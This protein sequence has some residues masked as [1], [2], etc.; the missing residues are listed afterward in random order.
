MNSYYSIFVHVNVFL[1]LNMCKNNN[2]N[3]NNNKNNSNN[4]NNNKIVNI[5]NFKYVQI[6]R[7]KLNF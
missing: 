4:N 3:N 1:S 7:G 5:I 6:P 2:N